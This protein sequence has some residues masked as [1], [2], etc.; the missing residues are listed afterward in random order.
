MIRECYKANTGI[1]FNEE[2]LPSVGIDPS[3]LYGVVPTRPVSLDVESNRIQKPPVI[4]ICNRIR[5]FFRHRDNAKDPQSDE[6]SFSFS[7]EEEEELHDAVSAKYDQLRNKK[8]WWIVEILP[9]PQ[10]KQ[11]GLD[12][13]WVH[14][15]WYVS[16][17]TIH[18]FLFIL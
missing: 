11:P 8:G 1:K 5:A 18:Y 6:S 7:T 10:V 13:A 17:E 15:C 16:I 2:L 14:H 3:T 9:F 4:P 12:G